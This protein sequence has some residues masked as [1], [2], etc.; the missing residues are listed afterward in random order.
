MIKAHGALYIA[1]NTAMAVI[2][3]LMSSALT[4]F[5]P[6]SG[7]TVVSGGES[8]LAVGIIGPLIF[9]YAIWRLV[10]PL[11]SRPRN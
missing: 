10:R 1:L 5:L 8:M 3:A 11:K 2:G 4:M 6:G 9:A 7:A